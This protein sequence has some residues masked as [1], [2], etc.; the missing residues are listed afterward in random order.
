MQFMKR[1]WDERYRKGDLP[2]D[3]GEADFHLKHIVREHNIKPCKVL[4]LGCGTGTNAIWLS[5]Q[6][7]RVTAI[8]LSPTVLELAT[9][10]IGKDRIKIIEGD[11]LKKKIS[12]GPF[13][14]VFDRGLFHSLDTRRD[15]MKLARSVSTYL[16]KDGLWLS[17]I[18][19][20]DGPKLDVGPPRLRALE[21]ISAVEPSFR[22]ISLK[23]TRLGK[24]RGKGPAAWECLMKKRG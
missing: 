14:F 6:G 1:D 19:S 3:T 16:R 17:L 10:K 9:K 20:A 15:R 18:G 7:F 8:D 21:I 13:G 12:G 5:K 24:L 11:I 22:I 2:W 23:A 4:E